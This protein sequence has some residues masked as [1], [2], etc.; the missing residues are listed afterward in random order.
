MAIPSQ[1]LKGEGVETRWEWPKVFLKLWLRY[2]PD[3]KHLQMVT[4]VIVVRK[5]VEPRGSVGSNPTPSAKII[6]K[7]DNICLF[8]KIIKTFQYICTIIK[9][10]RIKTL[11]IHY[12]YENF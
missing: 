10:E 3:Y 5:T 6:K 8:Y 7:T 1:A 4:K 2:S 9:K 12:Y 11:Y